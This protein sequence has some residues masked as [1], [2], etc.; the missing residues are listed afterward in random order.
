MSR[1]FPSKDT[2]RLCP[3]LGYCLFFAALAASFPRS[4]ARQTPGS[5]PISLLL[6]GWA[7]PDRG[8]FSIGRPVVV[9]PQCSST[10]A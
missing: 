5:A 2:A 1:S 8:D 4:A 10:A 6:S 3:D 7:P 9:H